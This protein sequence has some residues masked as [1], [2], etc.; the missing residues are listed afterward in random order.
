MGCV[1]GTARVWVVVWVLQK[2]KLYLE[3]GASTVGKGK[4]GLVCRELGAVLS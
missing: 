4:L 3:R 1:R 2:P